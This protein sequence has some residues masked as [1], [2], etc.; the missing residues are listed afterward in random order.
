L[1]FGAPDKETPHIAEEIDAIH[2]LFPDARCFTGAEASARALAE[3][4]PASNIVHI[5]SHAIFRQ[6]NPMFSAFKLADAWLNFYDICSMRTEDAL[7][8][9]SGCSTGVGGIYAGDEM[10]G[11]VRGFLYANAASL[12]VSLWAVNDPATAELMATFYQRLRG[13]RAPP[14][15]RRRCN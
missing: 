12:V 5:A 9:L 6:D 11:L 4:L 3:H 1:I 14:C 13:R 2:E 8:V 7:V 15:G 10:L